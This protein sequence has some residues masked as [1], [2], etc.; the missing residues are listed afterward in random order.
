MAVSAAQEIEIDQALEV[1][2]QT[3]VDTIVVV[4]SFGAL[5]GEQIEILV[6]KYMRAIEGSGKTVGI[7]AHNNQQ[8]GFANTIEAIIHG[9]DRVDATYAGLG[10]GAGNCPMELL[11]GFLRNPKFKIRPIWQLLQDHFVE[12]QKRMEWGP[13]AQYIITGQHNEHPRSAIDA[14]ATDARDKY[15]EFYDK[16]VVDF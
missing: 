3:P 13:Y 7:H 16:I 8:L 2:A 10:R 5:Y 6:K 9:A 14:R 4:D 11:I 15:V 12:L 1:L